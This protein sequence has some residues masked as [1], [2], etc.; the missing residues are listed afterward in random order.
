M[1]YEEYKSLQR[2]NIVERNGNYF[3]VCGLFSDI[4]FI[5]TQDLNDI[6]R[7]NEFGFVHSNLDYKFCNLVKD[8][9]VIDAVNIWLELTSKDTINELEPYSFIKG[10][11]IGINAV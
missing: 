7:E 6:G 8:T 9:I 2:G 10:Y 11:Q 4:D 3:I 5:D 1:T